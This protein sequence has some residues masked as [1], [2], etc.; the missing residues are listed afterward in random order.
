MFNRL[1]SALQQR[2][3]LGGLVL[4]LI[5]GA[6]FLAHGF[7]A[8]FV[9]TP[10]GMAQFFGAVGI[11]L[12]LLSAWL[13][14]LTH[15][16][17]GTMLLLGLLTRLNAAVHAFVMLVAT[18]KVHL[19]QGFFMSAIIVDAAGGQAMVGG[20]EFALTLAAAS[21][22]LVFVGPGA[23]ALDRVT[24]LQPRRVPSLQS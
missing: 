15:L 21:L 18:A 5:L 19:A 11:P 17:G 12:P 1:E 23:F 3:Q 2:E 20:Y 10:A 7:A 22:A 24:G 8:L 16:A 6:V 13:V 4:R 9:Y 14:A